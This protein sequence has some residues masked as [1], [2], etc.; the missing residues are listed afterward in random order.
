[1]L[2]NLEP[3]GEKKKKE[4]SMIMTSMAIMCVNS[5]LIFNTALLKVTLGV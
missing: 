4:T 2:C 1:M 3:K 5:G